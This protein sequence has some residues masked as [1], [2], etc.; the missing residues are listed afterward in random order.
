MQVI[1]EQLSGHRVGWKKALHYLTEHFSGGIR[2]GK[3]ANHPIV[4]LIDELELLLI[5]NQSV[6]ISTK[7]IKG[8]FV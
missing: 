1:Y 2:I 5:R 4:L 8:L 7:S 3:Q 6:T